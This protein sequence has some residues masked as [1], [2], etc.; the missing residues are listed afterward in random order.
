LAPYS[1]DADIDA[2]IEG[3]EGLAR[4]RGRWQRAAAG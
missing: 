2:L 4:E 3:L 1:E